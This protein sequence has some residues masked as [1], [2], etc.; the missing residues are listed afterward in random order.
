MTRVI[1]VH[2]HRPTRDEGASPDEVAAFVEYLLS[3]IEKVEAKRV[4]TGDEDKGH[5]F[6][7]NQYVEVAGQGKA[8]EPKKPKNK[9][10]K[11]AV[12]KLL[13]SGKA[14]T[15]NELLEATQAHPG[16]L[17]TVLSNLKHAKLA[18]PLGALNIVK[19]KS[20]HYQVV[21]TD[22]E[23]AGNG[24]GSAQAAIKAVTPPAPPAAPPA[25]S[26]PA[27]LAPIT[28]HPP[29]GGPLSSAAADEKYQKGLHKLNLLCAAGASMAAPDEIEGV[30]ATWKQ[31]KTNLMA[32]W[33]A[34][35]TGQAQTAAKAQ[36][37]PTDMEHM[38]VLA[39]FY[40]QAKKAGETPKFDEAH[41][42]WKAATAAAKGGGK[43]P[44]MP[45]EK[46][47]EP[48]PA[49]PA[50]EGKKGGDAPPSPTLTQPK[51]PK[52]GEIVPDDHDHLTLDHLANGSW[53]KGMAKLYSGLQ[54]K[55]TSKDA[56]TV[57]KGIQNTLTT[58]LKDSHT[59]QWLK[60]KATKL[61]HGSLEARLISSWAS[62]SGDGHSLSCALQ[63]AARDA[64][65]M[66]HD[67]EMA[68]LS[69]VK[70]YG[71][72]G[73]YKQAAKYLG[74]EL[75]SNEDR[76]AFKTALQEFTLAQYH[77]TQSHLKELGVTHVYAARGMKTPATNHGKQVELK[78]QPISSFSVNHPTAHSFSGGKSLYYVK[79]PRE[80]V[81]STY[82][83]GYG[84]A[85]EHELV[86]LSHPKTRAIEMQA[87]SSMTKAESVEGVAQGMKK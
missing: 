33:K 49:A 85:H 55:K 45:W 73:T 6:H 86:I 84:C 56:A 24:A 3:E 77:E 53:R 46:P 12:H 52:M 16:T 39:H 74:F 13:S 87:H 19:Q 7:G 29:E 14:F 36:V 20:G 48:K 78:L 69:A 22:G 32:Q 18:G 50:P 54:K 4:K 2:I 64:F 79:V 62:S 65:N 37:F 81:L 44:P 9:G 11:E 66:K 23:G 75:N 47:A 51:P 21:K 5:E 61:Q 70:D 25:A 30:A 67:V 42:H 43:A 76:Q 26:Q 63:L 1:H 28:A 58:R 17:T 68:A 8:D 41:A 82:V 80:Q 35:T 38:K 72:D 59:F 15:F 40:G 27:T 31:G 34:D 60:T 83:S 10:T 57:K 71:E